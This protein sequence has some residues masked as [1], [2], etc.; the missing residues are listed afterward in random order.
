MKYGSQFLA[1]CDP[2]CPVFITHLLHRVMS[3]VLMH[4]GVMSTVLTCPNASCRHYSLAPPRHV[5][6]TPL[7][8]R[9]M[10]SLLTCPTASCRHYSLAPPCHVDGSYVPQRHVNTSHLP[11]RVMSTRLTC[12]TPLCSGIALQGGS[13]SSAGMGGAYSLGNSR[14]YRRA[15]APQWA[16]ALLRTAV[17][18]RH[19]RRHLSSSSSSSAATHQ[20]ISY[21]LVLL[22]V[23]HRLRSL[24]RHITRASRGQ[25]AGHLWRAA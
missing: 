8:Q 21:G 1:T 4:L 24:R 23:P 18:T 5:D 12:P 13:G 17:A 3:T 9:V 11:H 10:S 14:S 22:A 16:A 19:H 15:C 7:P 6:T 2:R 20:A 25:A